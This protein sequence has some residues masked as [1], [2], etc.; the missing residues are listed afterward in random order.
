MR[1]IIVILVFGF[2]LPVIL[3]AQKKAAPVSDS[4]KIYIPNTLTTEGQGFGVYTQCDLQNVK[5]TVYDRW[6]IVVYQTDSLYKGGVMNWDISRQ[7]EG[8]YIYMITFVENS[9]GEM[10][11]KQRTGNVT[12]RK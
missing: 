2:L 1:K 5:A 3:H 4:C 12:V 6:G 7:P 10:I 11:E 9:Q 8:T